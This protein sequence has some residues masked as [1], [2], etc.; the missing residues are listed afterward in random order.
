MQ[1]SYI[2]K[3]EILLKEIIDDYKDDIITKEDFDSY[4]ISYLYELNNLKFKKTY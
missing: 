4:N 1:Q 3:Y 2:I